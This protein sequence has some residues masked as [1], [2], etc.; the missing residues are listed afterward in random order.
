LES[1]EVASSGEIRGRTAF[2]Q[3]KIVGIVG[4]DILVVVMTEPKDVPMLKH[5]TAVIADQ[6]GILSHAAINC[7]E[8]KIPCIVGAKNATRLLVDGD[9]IEMDL[10]TGFIKILKVHE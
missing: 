1:A 3:G 2:G 9:K 5:Y 4:E 7:R 6:G 10:D 8:L